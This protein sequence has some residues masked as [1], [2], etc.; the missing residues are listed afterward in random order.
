MEMNEKSTRTT[1]E[2]ITVSRAEYE[3]IQKDVAELRQE[4]QWLLEQ[5]GII[6]KHVFASTSEKT[7]DAVMEQMSL[8]FNEAEVYED[9][10]IERERTEV[11]AH[12]R[13][14][15]SGSVRDIVPKDIPVQTVDHALE[16]AERA[17]PVCGETMQEIGTEVVETLVFKPAEAY[18]RRDVY[19]NYACMSC[20]QLREETPIRKT[21][22]EPAII[23]GSFASPEAVAHIMTQKFVM[24][25]PLYRQEQEWKR[26]NILLSRQT[27]SNWLVRC[28]EDWLEPVYE[29][30]HDELLRSD[31]LHA[32]ETQIKVL[33]EEGRKATAKSYIWLYR[34][35]R[36]ERQQIVLYEYQSSRGG[37][38]PRAFLN[39][40]HGYLQSDGYGAYPTLT[41]V[42][43][44]G[45][46]AHA[47]RKFD[48]AVHA[49]PGKNK[50]GAPVEGEAYCTRLFA[51]EKELAELTPEERYKARL[52]L[53]KPVL[54]ALEAWANTKSVAPKSKLGEAMTYLKN[55]WPNLI[56]FLQDG[57]L[58]I[59]NNRAERSIKPFV[60]GRK[61]FLFANTPS[62]AK[63]AAIVYSLIET[64][65]ENA[66]D[67]YRYLCYVLQTAP[68]LD[69]N[70]P[71][72]V[73]PLLPANAPSEC[74]T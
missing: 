4:N 56:A 21:P 64:A 63:A 6:R 34:T 32:D 68:R 47:R 71:N 29:A 15:R 2:T 48:E 45:C 69:R 51:I 60:M 30:L 7:S 31:I 44:L 36:E 49:I 8:L 26:Q 62:G 17:C 13:E 66:L 18:L 59:S 58:E 12:S 10:R 27:M 42:T 74:K 67:P 25:S 33:H 11:K 61:N 3:A 72:W 57:R 14:K 20:K 9:K 65:K 52:E 1:D 39:G 46:W 54:D 37:R 53:E 35:G 22:R 16:D 41:G 38:N 5:L 43:H 55:Q 40:F 24:Y 70:T 23:P 28:A 73:A 50:T 19:H